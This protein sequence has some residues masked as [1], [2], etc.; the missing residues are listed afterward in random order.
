MKIK[1]IAAVAVNNAIGG[2]DNKIPWDFHPEDMKIFTEKTKSEGGTVVMGRKT[3][4]S[5]PEKFRPLP[6]RT[7]VVLTRSVNWNYD[8]VQ[9]YNDKVSLLE[10][11][12]TRGI[13]SLWV[14]GGAEVYNQFFEL[15][16]EL[17]IS[18]FDTKPDLAVA[19]FP[20]I[21]YD[22]W[23]EIESKA[24]LE[25]ANSPGFTHKVYKRK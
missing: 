7:N 5:L 19:F 8:G 15:A 18:H 23:E 3:F 9:V 16:D 6:N 1:I 13:A 11:L 24:Y 14:C 10:H 12:N 25:Y 17:H 20:S 21:N 22:I 4:L 2:E